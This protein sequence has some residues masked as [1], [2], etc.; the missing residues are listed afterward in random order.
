MGALAMNLWNSTLGYGSVAPRIGYLD[1]AQ[2]VRAERI[3][4]ARMLWKGQHRRAFLEEGRTQANFPQMRANGQIITPY[5]TFNLLRL[6]TTTITDLLLG[7]EPSLRVADDLGGDALAELVNRSDLHRVFYT[8]AQEASWAAETTVEIVRWD[9][10]VYI[11]NLR[12]GEVYPLGERNPDGQYSAYRRFATTRVGER[13]L[14]LET[15]YFPGLITRQCFWLDE[16][17]LTKGSDAGLSQWPVKRADGSDLLP[18][19]ATG[20]DWNTIVWAANEID[21]DQPTCDY[22]GLIDLQDELNAKQTQLYRVIAKH[23]DPKIV[24]D[25]SMAA[26]DG[27]VPAQHDALFANDVDK[28]AKYVT[29]NAELDAAMRD[30]DFT[31]SAFCAAAELSPILLGIKQGATPDAARKLRLEA[32]KSLSRAKRKATHQRAFIRTAVDT[33]MML[34]NAGRRVAV[35]IG[36]ASIELRDGLPT[37][38]MDEANALATLTGG[39]QVMSLKRAVERQLTDP[40]AVEEEL[41]EIRR[42]SEAATPPILLGGQGGTEDGEDSAGDTMQDASMT[43]Q[44]AA[45]GPNQTDAVAGNDLKSTV[46]AL[47]A[48]QSLQEAYYAGKLPRE[49]AV[50]TVTTMLGMG[51]AEA[52]VLFPEIEPEPPGGQPAIAAAPSADQGV[53]A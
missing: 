2:N 42:E 35:A 33:A 25:R 46:G 1:D 16:Q 51:E 10:E 30:R 20:I 24:F 36:Q 6:V 34:E 38:E 52:G 44:P 49:A 4:V 18:Q 14:L 45:G 22:D 28:A 29:W 5:L 9:G 41:K 11:R 47:N 27:T 43:E 12:P 8:A 31:V 15:T 37:D 13:V 53:T 17:T 32:T 7:E 40:A 48:I 50:A 26:P 23:A 3:R 21:E 39:K 19:E